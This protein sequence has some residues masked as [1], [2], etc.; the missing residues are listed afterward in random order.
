ML[1]DD[2]VYDNSLI[3]TQA[4]TDIQVNYRFMANQEPDMQN[5]SSI[6]AVGLLTLIKAFSKYALKRNWSQ[7]DATYCKNLPLHVVRG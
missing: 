1:C 3:R 7:A 5:K 6:K 4:L 2:R